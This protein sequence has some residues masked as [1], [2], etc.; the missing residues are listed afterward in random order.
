VVEEGVADED[1]K[2]QTGMV[3]VLGNETKAHGVND[4]TGSAKRG[5]AFDA[6]SILQ[7]WHVL[8][9][10][11]DDSGLVFLA[12]ATVSVVGATI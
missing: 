2:L 9:R 1:V 11:A 5:A 3:T 4:A 10:L 8:R 6:A 12:C 7:L